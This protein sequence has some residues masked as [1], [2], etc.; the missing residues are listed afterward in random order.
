MFPH[1]N[2]SCESV[3]SKQVIALIAS[4]WKMTLPSLL[5]FFSFPL[6]SFSSL[7]YLLHDFLLLFCPFFSSFSFPP[8]FLFS[9]FF[10]FAY[11][12]TSPLPPFLSLYF[13]FPS[14]FIYACYTIIYSMLY[15]NKH[16]YCI[17]FHFRIVV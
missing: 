7:Y 9:I 8:D 6:F 12:I 17:I 3:T 5:F 2:I 10:L 15:N 11:F 14:L 16:S 1:L 13:S 4:E